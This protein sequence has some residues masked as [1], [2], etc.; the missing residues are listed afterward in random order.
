[1]FKVE[2]FQNYGK[3]HFETCVASATS[4]QHG[5]QAIASAY[6]DYTKKS[7]E[8]TKSFVEKL[9]GVKSLDKAMEAQTDFA[10]SAYETF[11]AESQKIA[12]L[13][14][15]LAKQAFKPVETVVS[16]FT[17]AAQ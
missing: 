13:Y 11:V 6:G 10:R 3:E 9:S 4:V 2:D 12:G 8:D 14:S 7:F 5:L 15:D 1:M 16:K 17:P